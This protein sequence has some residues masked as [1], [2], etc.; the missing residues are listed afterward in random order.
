MARRDILAARRLRAEMSWSEFFS[1][2][3]QHAVDV[4]DGPPPVDRERL[5]FL[6][7]RVAETDQA[8][9]DVLGALVQ[10]VRELTDRTGGVAD[11]RDRPFDVRR[12]DEALQAGHQPV[13]LVGRI[14][15]AWPQVRRVLDH[16]DRCCRCSASKPRPRRRRRRRIRHLLGVDRFHQRIDVRNRRRRGLPDVS[17]RRLASAAESPSN[18]FTAPLLSAARPVKSETSSTTLLD[19]VR[20]DRDDQFVGVVRQ[21]LQAIRQRADLAADVA[22]R[23]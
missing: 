23:G 22:E 6:Q 9:G 20:V 10:I 18:D 13:D 21:L 14:V 8:G 5:V 17:L 4:V 16:A 3:A 15:R 19:L 1:N 7:T 2:S 12:A 11:F